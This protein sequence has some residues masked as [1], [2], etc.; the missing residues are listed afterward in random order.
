MIQVLTK[1]SEQISIDEVKS[2]IVNNVPEN[3]RIEFKR[4]L[5]SEGS[6]LDSWYN[7]KNQIGKYAR[8]KIL[9]EAVAFANAFG[10]VLILGIE[11][12]DSKPPAAAKICSIPRCADLEER[13]KLI[14]RDCVEPELPNIEIFAV[15]TNSERGVVILRTGRSFRAP[16]RV[17]PTGVC[18]IRRSDRCE[19]LSMREIQDLTLNLNRGIEGLKQRLLDRSTSFKKKHFHQLTSYLNAFGLRMTAV[20]VL[21]E[22]QL[23]AVYQQGRFIEQLSPPIVEVQRRIGNTT[24]SLV[25]L[26]NVLNSAPSSWRPM[27]RAAC[28]DVSCNSSTP[29]IT[30]FSY[31]EISCDGLLEIQFVSTQELIHRYQSNSPWT[32]NSD[33]P[34]SMFAGI[35]EWVEKVRKQAHAVTAEYVIEIEITATD[36]KAKVEFGAPSYD[37]TPATTLPIGTKVFPQYPFVHV[38]DKVSIV[39]LFERDLWNFLGRD[40]GDNQGCLSF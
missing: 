18:P 1:P 36:D 13:L 26:L 2:L 39:A 40:L 6:T 11:E 37:I 29:G 12:T 34:V 27:L 7:G 3:E 38:D 25:S 15:R 30:L 35:V 9:E 24:N 21:D 28:A 14:F 19:K 17:K 5:P 33:I 4:D 16:H 23:N 10:G 8:N 32:L 31:S 22:V 20:P